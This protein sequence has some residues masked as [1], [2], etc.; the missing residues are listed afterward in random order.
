[1]ILRRLLPPVLVG[2]LYFSGALLGMTASAMSEGIAIFWLPNG[3]L[4]AALLLAPKR[5][6]PVYLFAAV[7]AEV[8]A[9]MHR[10]TLGQALGFAAINLSECLLAAILLRRVASPFTFNRL[11]HAVWFGVIAL[12]L[13]PGLAALP[14]AAIHASAAGAQISFWS[15]WRIWWVGDSLGV[16]MVVP[17]VLGWLSDRRKVRWWSALEASAVVATALA[18]AW[19]I[20]AQTGEETGWLVDSPILMLLVLLWPAIRF[21]VHETAGVGLL[22]A[23]V[24]ILTNL[25]GL[26]P[27][28]SAYP[29][30][31]VLKVQGYL[32]T[33]LFA[34]LVLA[35]L[36]QELRDRNENLQARE[37]E[38]RL[39]QAAVRQLNLELESRVQARTEELEA[40]NRLLEALASVDALTGASN[41]RHF[42]EIARIE[43]ERA[44][45]LGLPVAA[46]ML[47]LDYF[48]QVN[49]KYGHE[50]GDR[51]L[52]TFAN[53]VHSTLRSSDIFARLGGEEFII[54]LPG[55]KQEDACALA[56]RM[57]EMTES[58]KFAKCP[59]GI[60][61]SIGI[62]VLGS[63]GAQ[64]LD[65]LMRQADHALYQSKHAGRNRVSVA[66]RRLSQAGQA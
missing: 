66:G 26:G 53:A 35:A 56:E 21:G 25:E 33:L 58:L 22:I 59:E 61:V 6:W 5:D 2:L 30:A 64:D 13:A 19:M 29:E 16:L 32:A 49:D 17:L 24:A 40:A 23:V 20:F 43:V 46:M 8:L 42:L 60:T 15:Y 48:K 31:T 11:R 63:D 36:L 34:A 37:R 7:L 10:F 14:G 18:L 57:R 55:Q 27:F 28:V 65:G 45:R 52:Q 50:T 38:L 51:V 1:M 3:I 62:A 39:S 44:Q 9:D 41:R 12:L 47:D 4:L 54:L